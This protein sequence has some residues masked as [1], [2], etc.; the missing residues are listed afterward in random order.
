SLTVFFFATVITGLVLYFFNGQGAMITQ[1]LPMILVIA[2]LTGIFAS[3]IELTGHKGCDNLTL[4]IGSAIFAV[5]LF[6][7]GDLYLYVYLAVAMLILLLAYRLKSITV[8]GMVTA[9]LIA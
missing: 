5:L 3:F 8:D 7:Y 4:P 1:S 2:G 6:Q 9:L